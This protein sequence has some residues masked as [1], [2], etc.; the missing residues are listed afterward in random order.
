M[1]IAGPVMRLNELEYVDGEVW[2]NVWQTDFIARID[3]DTD[4]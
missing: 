2:A 3:P 1:T 4:R